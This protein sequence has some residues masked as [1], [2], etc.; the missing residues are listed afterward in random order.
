LNLLAEGTTPRAE[1]GPRMTLGTDADTM[2]A[3]VFHCARRRSA[4]CS[5]SKPNTTA[6]NLTRYSGFPRQTASKLAVKLFRTRVSSFRGGKEGGISMP[7]TRAFTS[8]SRESSPRHIFELF[9]SR[10]I[11]GQSARQRRQ[12]FHS[13][14]RDR[15]CLG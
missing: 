9:P 14:Q 7:P 2:P 3:S 15:G 1:R 12:L 4:G 13:R 5:K 11:S 8:L 6:E 10:R